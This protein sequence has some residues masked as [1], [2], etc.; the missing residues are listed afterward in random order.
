MFRGIPFSLSFELATSQYEVS[1]RFRS[2]KRTR[3]RT[4]VRHP[5]A[6]PSKRFEATSQGDRTYRVILEH[7]HGRV[8]PRPCEGIEETRHGH[9][10]QANR[11]HT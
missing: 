3:R 5:L 11:H 8:Y 7:A 1:F 10:D 4:G 2:R 6:T 9:G